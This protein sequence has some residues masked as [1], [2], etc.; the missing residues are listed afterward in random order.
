MIATLNNQ[1]KTLYSKY[2]GGKI[3]DIIGGG[4]VDENAYLSR[5]PRVLWILKEP[6]AVGAS[7]NIAELL[8]EKV[9]QFYEDGTPISVGRWAA[10]KVM[11]V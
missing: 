6:Y 7:N 10:A 2:F 8:R 5:R 3:G 11:G 9:D 4:I 1:L